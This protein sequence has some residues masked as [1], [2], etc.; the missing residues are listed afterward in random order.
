LQGLLP[1]RRRWPR[2]R[3]RI[4]R[5][6]EDPSATTAKTSQKTPARIPG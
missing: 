2:A 4:R 6:S 1:P 5:E 3:R